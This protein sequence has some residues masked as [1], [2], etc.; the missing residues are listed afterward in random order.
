MEIFFLFLPCASLCWPFLWP[1]SHFG[2]FLPFSLAFPFFFIYLIFLSFCLIHQKVKWCPNFFL[3]WPFSYLF[4]THSILSLLVPCWLLWYSPYVSY[5]PLSCWS[6]NYL[7]NP[8]FLACIK[9]IDLIH[10]SC[11]KKIRSLQFIWYPHFFPTHKWV[12][13]FGLPSCLKKVQWWPNPLLIWQFSCLLT[14]YSLVV[15]S[16]FLLTF[17]FAFTFFLVFP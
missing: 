15:A 13:E 4:T 2:L 11:I 9:M 17:F 12:C 1:I 8:K 14:K 16:T 10:A 6:F 7:G 3:I 5:K